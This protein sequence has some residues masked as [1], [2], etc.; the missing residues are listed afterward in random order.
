MI[1]QLTKCTA[2]LLM[3]ASL[4]MSLQASE[5]RYVT[6]ELNEYVR[7]GAGD[8]YRIA[9]TV[10][11][12]EK[13]TVLEKRGKYSLIQDSRNRQVWILNN[14][15]TN[16]PSAKSRIPTL[17][18]QVE[19]LSLKLNKIDDDWNQRTKEIRRRLG[20]AEQQSSDLLDINAQ[21]KREVS[22]LKN[23]NKELEIMQDVEQRE[24]M[25]KW[26]MYGG[27]VLGVGLLLGLI[28]PFILP[29]RRR[30]NGWV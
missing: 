4:P 15:L 8:N 2:I 20:Q 25:I 12:G 24:I 16:E 18:K 30:N 26:F 11:A 23:K 14:K 29:K 28:I 19:E 27:I 9:G 21:L 22:V 1:K 5:S 7:R 3:V 10:K 13:V 17:E 6:D